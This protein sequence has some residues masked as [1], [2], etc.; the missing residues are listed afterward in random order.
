MVELLSRIER[1]ET[2]VRALR[3]NALPDDPQFVIDVPRNA[4]T[5][6]PWARDEALG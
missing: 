4:T 5:V 2:D 3:A 6:T 1:L